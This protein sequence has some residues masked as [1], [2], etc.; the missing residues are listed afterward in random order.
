[1][2]K[3]NELAEEIY[4][5]L[6]HR[7][8]RTGPKDLSKK[9]VLISNIRSRLENKEPIR[10]LQFWGGAKNPN[11]PTTIADSCEIETL[12]HLLKIHDEVRQYYNPGLLVTITTGDGRVEYANGISAVSTGQYHNS[13]SKIIHNPKY[14]GLFTLM[15]VSVLYA[16]NKQFW[17]TLQA[18]YNEV[19]TAFDSTPLS[20]RL[21]RDGG[22][23][24]SVLGNPKP[25]TAR[26]AALRYISVMVTEERVGLYRQFEDYIRTF[27]IKFHSDYNSV[28]LKFLPDIKN[29]FLTSK[30]SL[31]FYTGSK[32]NITQP[33]QAVG[34]KERG[35]IIFISQK[36]MSQKGGSLV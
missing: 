18:T 36:R 34:K 32:G 33:W 6:N 12:N 26:E 30:C 22:S 3:I 1:M 28:Y 31:S 17:T 21:L 14:G 9:E 4:N 16:R 24:I 35:K 7:Q 20:D 15:P 8:H 11:L 19:A 2:N 5:I 29:P 23:N 27:F 13:L 25:Y 10:F